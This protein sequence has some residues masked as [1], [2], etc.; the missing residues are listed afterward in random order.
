[1]GSNPIFRGPLKAGEADTAPVRSNATDYEALLPADG[2]E[3]LLSRVFG[4]AFMDV[5]ERD[6]RGESTL[7]EALAL[8]HPAILQR[9]REALGSIER[10]V[11]IQL[12]TMDRKS[13]RYWEWRK[14][15]L[16]FLQF[17]QL[18][19]AEARQRIRQ[20]RPAP[21][22]EPRVIQRQAQKAAL[23]RLRAAH[24]EEFEQY[25]QQEQK[26][27]LNELAAGGLPA[28]RGVG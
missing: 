21:P 26:R 4:E 24:P 14:A 11:Q 16:V 28:S 6:T 15:A 9:W 19:S 18:R 17:V 10:S 3:E 25:F 8:R 5:V 1:L 13:P 22:C 20:P 7:Q 2:D 23:E 12:A 27:I